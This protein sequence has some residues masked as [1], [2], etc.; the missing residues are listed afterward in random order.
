LRHISGFVNALRNHLAQTSSLDDP[1]I[2]HYLQVIQDSSFKM[3][4]L[5]DGLLTLSR[6]GR[7]QM[8]ELPVDLNLIVQAALERLSESPLVTGDSQSPSQPVE[9]VIGALPAVMGDATLL[10]QVFANLLENAIKFSRGRSP[11]RVEV[12]T[13]ADG[14]LFV[15]DNGVGFSMEYADQLFGAFQRL[16]PAS[17]FEGTGIGL[18]IVQRI[19]HRHGGMIWAESKVGHGATFYF[20]FKENIKS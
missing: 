9:F 3:G 7:R 13:L 18:A 8:A 4:Q 11:A 1:Q 6:V 16:H 19:I 15:R 12:G 2:A 10:Q 14:T 5:I 17:E 20:K